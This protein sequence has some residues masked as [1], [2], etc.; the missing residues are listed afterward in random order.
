[1]FKTKKTR[2]IVAVSLTLLSA[3]LLST[4]TYAWFAMNT[5]AGADDFKVEAYSDSLFLQISNTSATSGFGID[6][7]SYA[8]EDT[9]DLRLVTYKVIDTDTVYNAL[10]FVAGTGNYDD[11]TDDKTYY[12]LADSDAEGALTSTVFN[13]I[14]AA[15]ELEYGSELTGYYKNVAFT[16]HNTGVGDGSTVYYEKKGTDYVKV[17]PVPT[18]TD[19][20]KG[21]Y[22]VTGVYNALTSSDRYTAADL[23]A[24]D[25]YWKVDALGNY[26]KV[27]GLVPGTDLTKYLVV[28]TATAVTETEF[29][30]T[31]TYYAK[32]GDDY[33][34]LGKPAAGEPIV[35]H[36][37]WGRAYSTS[38][39][40]VQANNTLNVLSPD[41]AA[42]DYY[43]TKTLWLRQG[44]DTN[45][46]DNL[47]VSSVEITGAANSMN[48][49]LRVL[50]VATSSV[51]PTTVVTTVYDAGTGKFDGSEDEGKLFSKLLGNAQETITVDV[52][53]YF[54][55]TDDV[56][57]NSALG[58]LNGQ[59][60]SI[61][62]SI[63]ELDY[64][65]IGTA[66]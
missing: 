42:A 39:E 65:E 15:S 56:A 3:L 28:D 35:G 49:A 29:D 21:L 58:V 40:D 43:L 53:I 31:T 51:D 60:I 30:G 37:Y 17:T 45:H 8:S 38:L 9:K 24:N 55:G 52:Y 61:E 25:Q 57:K 12:K 32:S 64:N 1:M 36:I 41:A 7:I 54:D 5:R 4:A 13:Y 63:D 46:A 19:S 47:R 34:C 16:L 26:S 2:L 50:F 18:D 33:I 62:F 11:T 14:N 48:P 44:E 6:P 66:P 20:V 59:S 10:T 27:S 22:T 23:A